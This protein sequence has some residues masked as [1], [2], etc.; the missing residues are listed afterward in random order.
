MN[1]RFHVVSRA[2]KPKCAG[3][4]EMKGPPS[5]T[6]S[7]ALKHYDLPKLSSRSSS[8]GYHVEE[9]DETETVPATFVSQGLLNNCPEGVAENKGDDYDWTKHEMERLKRLL[10]EAKEENEFLRGCLVREDA[11][12]GIV[13]ELASVEYGNNDPPEIVGTEYQESY[14]DE[15]RGAANELLRSLIQ[16]SHQSSRSLGEGKEFDNVERAMDRMSNHLHSLE[17]VNIDS[18]IGTE[19][20]ATN[21]ISNDPPSCPKNTV[22]SVFVKRSLA[23]GILRILDLTANFR[24]CSA[25]KEKDN[26]EESTFGELVP[27]DINDLILACNFMIN[28][29][30]ILLKEALDLAINVKKE[31]D[32]EDVFLS[33]QIGS[34]YK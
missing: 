14:S 2:E 8:I 19:I 9:R 33:T 27:V 10:Q 3:R 4:E 30:G 23:K 1:N 21:H 12:D 24:P 25:I 32:A 18:K 31:V 15:S 13:K 16:L 5:L 34:N 17:L 11:L 7:R 28:E 29:R 26:N 20:F 22:R 6:R